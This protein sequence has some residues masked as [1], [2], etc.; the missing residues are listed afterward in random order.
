MILCKDLRGAQG[1]L[2]ALINEL[3]VQG[4]AYPLFKIMRTKSRGKEIYCKVEYFEG[5][6]KRTIIDRESVEFF[7]IL[8]GLC[9]D[10]KK[11]IA[12]NDL[13]LLET[14]EEQYRDISPVEI[15]DL[16]ERKY[17]KLERRDILA[18][19]SDLER[20]EPDPSD[21]AKAPYHKAEFIE[22][23]RTQITSRGLKVRSKSEAA[24]CEILYANGIEFRYEE[25]IYINGRKV[26]PDFTIRR[27]SDGKIFYWEHCGMMEDPAYLN[28]YHEKIDIYELGDIVPWN[29]LIL[30][31]DND[32]NIDLSYIEAI[33][34]TVLAA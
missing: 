30:T 4:K 19:V 31:Y 17:P 27:K 6:R 13:F 1:E 22:D 10:A 20:S 34:R 18:A 21:W 26:I 24:I 5:K 23:G 12:E 15:I 3:K 33:V 32:G 8:K 29:N 25:V 9:I 11:E 16:L 2:R 14:L 7:A 28:R